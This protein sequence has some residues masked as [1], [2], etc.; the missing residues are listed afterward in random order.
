[1]WT[2]RGF[3][4]RLRL[5]SAERALAQPWTFE[6]SRRLDRALAGLEALKD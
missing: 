4:L 3:L 6:A 1:M 2:M 5:G